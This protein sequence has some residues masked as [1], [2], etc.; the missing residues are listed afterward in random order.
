MGMPHQIRVS[1]FFSG[2]RMH[3]RVLYTHPLY[4]GGFFE[5]LKSHTTAMDLWAKQSEI[6]YTKKKEKQNEQF[7][8]AASALRIE[9]SYPL[10]GSFCKHTSD[11]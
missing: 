6:F 4:H 2:L 8:G 3:T 10:W 5:A 9:H 7:S 11:E 1:H